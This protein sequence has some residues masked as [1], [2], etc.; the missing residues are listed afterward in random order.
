MKDEKEDLQSSDPA[1]NRGWYPILRTDVQKILN[2]AS[3]KNGPSLVCVWTAMMDIANNERSATFDTPVAAI[4][5]K[6]GLSYKATLTALH[7]LQGINL[8]KIT[9]R[10]VFGS[11]ENEISTYQVI[12]KLSLNVNTNKNENAK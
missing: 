7:R 4:A 6:A 11:K 5:R 8:L 9:T 1:Q 3:A 12:T 2:N 10:R